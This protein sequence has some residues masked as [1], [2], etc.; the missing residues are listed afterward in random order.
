MQRFS[1]KLDT[2][3]K[4]IRELGNKSEEITQN[5]SLGAKVM[6]NINIS[7]KGMEARMRAN[8]CLVGKL[9]LS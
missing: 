3:E 4:R 2:A 9:Q 7:V 5:T 8:K 1:S 6:E